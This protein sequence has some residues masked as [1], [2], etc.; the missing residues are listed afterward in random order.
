MEIA[1]A[2]L[3]PQENS[4]NNAKRATGLLMQMGRIAAKVSFTNYSMLCISQLQA[5]KTNSNDIIAPFTFHPY[6]K[7]ET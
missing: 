4:A 2:Q 7:L 5:L 3:E 1:N 6:L